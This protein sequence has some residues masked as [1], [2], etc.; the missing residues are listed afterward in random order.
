L[1]KSVSFEYPEAKILSAQLD[2]TL[3]GKT[4]ESY[5]LKDY[6]KL[7]RIGFLNRNLDDFKMLVGRHVLGAES[8]GNTILVRLEGGVNFM[9]APEYGGVILYHEAGMD[10]NYHMLLRFS[11]GDSL[12]VR[13]TSMGLIYAAHDEELAGL[14]MYKRDYLGAPNPVDVSAEHFKELV[15]IRGTQL[16]PILVGKDA[17]MTGLSNSAFQDI[18]WQAG[19]HPHRKA[20]GLTSAQLDSLYSAIKGLIE[21]RLSLRGKDEVVDLFG[22]PGDYTPKMGPNMKDKHCPRCG[23]SVEK[24]SH[25]GGQVYFCPGCQK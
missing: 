11:G 20:S 14:Y 4:I 2:E 16:K 6:E 9:L 8:R 5:D 23:A 15:S 10:A 25:G 12:T 17:I 13:L 22:R 24:M 7:Q 18:L 21:E 1:V 19:I 3:K